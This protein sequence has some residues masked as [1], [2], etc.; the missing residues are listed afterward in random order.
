MIKIRFREEL[1]RIYINT[2]GLSLSQF[3]EKCG[4]TTKQYLAIANGGDCSVFTLYKIARVLQ[5]DIL[6]LLK[7]VE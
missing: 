5:L 6:H 1:V 3:C 2:T 4:I 7:E